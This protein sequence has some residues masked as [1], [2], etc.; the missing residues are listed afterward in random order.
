MGSPI[1][2]GHAR[3][4]KGKKVSPTYMSWSA[5]KGRCLQP[6]NT[7]YADYGGRGITVCERWL[8]FDNFLAD[9]G[10]R[11]R[12]TTIHRLDGTKG[13]EPGNCTWATDQ[14]Q[15]ANR[16]YRVG[17]P[18]ALK[19]HCKWGHPFDEYNTLH[20]KNGGRGCRACNK[21]ARE[22]TNGK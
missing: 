17:H 5:M 8:V 22:R 18:N 1:R 13:Y 4:T 19:T 6:N 12:G 20:K 16:S 2:H 14:E 7:R 21:A 3:V 11:P 15:C 10:P 9:M